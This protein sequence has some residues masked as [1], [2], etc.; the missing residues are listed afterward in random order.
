MRQC[1]KCNAPVA[2]ET[3]F[4]TACGAPVPVDPTGAGGTI[5][6]TQMMDAAPGKTVMMDESATVPV[7]SV[8]AGTIESTK[9]DI[10]KIFETS[11]V[12]PQCYSPLKKGSNACDECG[13]RLTGMF[14]KSCGREVTDGQEFCPVCKSATVAVQPGTPPS[15]V[16]AGPFSSTGPTVAVG[17]GGP[18]SVPPPGAATA[19]VPAYGAPPPMAPPPGPPP[20]PS[21][22]YAAPSYAPPAYAQPVAAKAKGKG[23]MVFLIVFLVILLGGG[24]FSLWYFVLRDKGV[25][26]ADG[27]PSA[28]T[29]STA[30]VTIPGPAGTMSGATTPLPP[31]TGPMA[32]VD[33]PLIDPVTGQPVGGPL[34]TTAGPLTPGTVT[35]G[36]PVP[37]RR[38][39]AS[40]GQPATP[41]GTTPVT[42]VTP[43]TP[44]TPPPVQESPYASIKVDA[45]ALRLPGMNAMI[46]VTI[47]SGSRNFGGVSATLQSEKG[48]QPYSVTVI[49]TNASTGEREQTYSGSGN[50]RINYADQTVVIRRRG[51]TLTIN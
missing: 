16:P 51:E 17:M 13:Y 9:E 2:D 29:T 34:P 42:P 49:Y 20:M 22:G 5:I 40:A 1:P 43:V 23:G 45:S 3:R 24:G 4:C 10:N 25:P 27:K 33:Q 18:P 41:A 26:A 11:G 14:C 19:Q 36:S 21:P 12:C 15:G 28:S 44:T 37:G 30:S 6:A 32:G 8:S 50:V 47:G 35:S 46:S 31:E 7:Q 48:S 38:P 39:T